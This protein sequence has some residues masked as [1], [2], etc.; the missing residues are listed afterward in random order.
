MTRIRRIVA[1]L[2]QRAKRFKYALLLTDRV[3]ER[4]LQ[5]VLSLD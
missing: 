5:Y 1:E 2:L 3:A 4:A